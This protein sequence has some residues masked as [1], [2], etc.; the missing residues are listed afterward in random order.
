MR[1]RKLRLPPHNICAMPKKEFP[2]ET[3]LFPLPVAL[4]SVMD[5]PAQ[6]P[7]VMTVAW[8][9]VV[10]S[11]PALLS[12]SIRPS[13]YS[14]GLIGVTGDFVINIPAASM[15]KEVDFCGVRSGRDIDK[16]KACAF[17][18]LPSRKVSSPLIAEC[19]V[20]IECRLKDVI[21]LG[22]HD[23]FIGEAALVHANKEILTPKDRI[24]YAKAAPLVFN[25]GEYWSLGKYIGRYGA[26]AK[27][28]KSRG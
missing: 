24:D 4:V 26:C 2:P 18:A 17:T 1:P 25:Q 9:G 10:C 22:S 11:A 27:D 3:A 7:N 5:K 20:N 6:R 23:M 14:H 21:S 12:V 28:L 16:F 8:C 19:P 13:R 15:L